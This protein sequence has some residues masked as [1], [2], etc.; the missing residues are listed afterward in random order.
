MK[1]RRYVATL[2]ALGATC[3][4]AI[5]QSKAPLTDTRNDLRLTPQEQAVF[6]AE[7]R[8]MLGSVQQIVQ[9]LGSA[10]RALIAEAARRSGNSMARA[11]PASIR[12]KLPRGFRVL[13][14][15]THLMF[16]EL[17]TRAETDDMDMLAGH[18]GQTMK[19]C[20]ACHATFK[21]R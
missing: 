8:L 10:D 16:E 14:E 7:M 5:A 3:S 13:G 12:A 17:A 1:T 4:L 19:Q 9:G 6:L 2:A 21:V 20:M 11:T 18:L 15:P